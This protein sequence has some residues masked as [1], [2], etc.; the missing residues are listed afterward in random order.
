MKRVVL[1]LKQDKAFAR[2]TLAHF[3][4]EKFFQFAFV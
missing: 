2:T 4:T 3:G 1:E